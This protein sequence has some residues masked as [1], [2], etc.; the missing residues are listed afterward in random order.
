MIPSVMKPYRN[1]ELIKGTMMIQPTTDIMNDNE[2]GDDVAIFPV[3]LP[4][5]LLALSLINVTGF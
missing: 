3:R 1:D 2:S 5:F 4:A